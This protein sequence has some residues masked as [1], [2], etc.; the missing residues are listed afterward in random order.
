[1]PAKTRRSFREIYRRLAAFGVAPWPDE[2]KLLPGQRWR[3]EILK[4]I[5][6]TDVVLAC[7]SAKLTTKRGYVQKKLREALD[8]ADHRPDGAIFLIPL[9]L[10]T[11]P[12]PD[13]LSDLHAVNYFDQRGVRLLAQ[14][15]EARADAIVAT[16]PGK[17]P[18]NPLPP[19][20][21]AGG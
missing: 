2:E 9:L 3:Q 18:D 17:P 20:G 6:E 10:E 4:A 19:T 14:A 5:R 21:S 8:E 11:C 7:L 12:V 15:L 16:I 1:M 13:R